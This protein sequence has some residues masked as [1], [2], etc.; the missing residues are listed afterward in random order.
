MTAR[1]EKGVSVGEGG[2]GKKCFQEKLALVNSVFGHGWDWSSVSTEV[3][4][5][6]EGVDRIDLMS[7]WELVGLVSRICERGWVSVCFSMRDWSS[8]S[9]GVG[10]IVQECLPGSPE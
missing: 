2:I 7:L 3:G 1:S 5:N 8:V 10:G 9:A 6:G 4:G